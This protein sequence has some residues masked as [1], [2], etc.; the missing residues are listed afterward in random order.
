MLSPATLP[1]VQD[2]LRRAGLDGWLLFDFRGCNPVA[3][4]MAGLGHAGLVSRRWLVWVPAQ[5]APRAITH[6]IEQGPWAHWPAAWEKV[7]YARWQEFEAAIGACVRGRRVAMEYSPG[8]AVPYVDRI[9]AGVLDLVR[10]QGGTVVSSGELVT[11]FFAVWTP[12]QVAAHHANAEAIR[13]VALDAFARI[14]RAVH[15]GQAV[16]EHE[17]ADEIVAEFTRRGLVIDHGPI[18][19]AQEHAASPHF[20]PSAQDPR[21]FRVGDLA[22][23]DLF[24][25]SPDGMWADQTWMAVI[26]PPSARQAAVFEAVR[27]ARDA[28]IAVLG[29]RL[30]SGTPVRGGEADAAARA[31][32]EG[33]GFGP[34]FTHRTG[35]SIDARGLHGSGPHMDDFE[36]RE[37]R[38][39]LPG[40]G[41][42]IEPGIY[43]PDEFGVRLEVNGYVDADGGLVITPAE[44]QR[45]LIV[46]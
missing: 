29:D 13:Q 31:V 30:A 24:A 25:T 12:A 5:G 23:I 44:I 11:R 20:A 17:V 36:T 14:G 18:V 41:F 33:K 28:A 8:D 21:A 45:E 37:E 26:G 1:S 39:L 32:I 34:W 16:H 2:A 15:A 22:L 27:E 46:L 6:A 7:V 42:S 10:A 3:G 19:A 35:H 4:V 43:L 9:P 38:V 40:V